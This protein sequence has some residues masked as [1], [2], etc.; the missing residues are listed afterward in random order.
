[1]T[2]VHRELR[3]DVLLETATRQWL[4]EVPAVDRQVG[5]EGCLSPGSGGDCA[6]I[7][8]WRT[9]RTFSWLA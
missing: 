2:D 9:I 1:M 4:R 7:T 5:V 3:Q 6:I 8:Q